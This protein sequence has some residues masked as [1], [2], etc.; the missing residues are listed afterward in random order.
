MV[1]LIRPQKSAVV[2]TPAPQ[3]NLKRPAA[4]TLPNTGGST[5]VT[6]ANKKYMC[7]ISGCGSSFP[8]VCK[9][10]C[11]K[12]R[13][14]PD[15]EPID[16][17]VCTKCQSEIVVRS[18]PGTADSEHG[19]CSKCLNFTCLK[20]NCIFEHKTDSAVLNHIEK[21]HNPFF[22]QKCSRCLGPKTRTD[23]DLKGQC[24]DSKCK[25]LWCLM[26]GCSFDHIS[27]GYFATH[28]TQIHGLQDLG[29]DG[30]VNHC[31]CKVAKTGAGK[32]AQC[33]NCNRW[34][35]LVR[36]C[37]ATFENRTRLVCHLNKYHLWMFS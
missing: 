24:P 2:P 14:H 32:F 22:V 26:E 35:C 23:G 37:T 20:G 15:V 19:S 9:L 21:N 25:A 13:C 6:P 30:D 27:P 3:M 34:W 31:S 12:R 16:S 7:N 29:L 18:K 11:H 5:A 4:A 36:P 1:S 28:Q 17:T 33:P 10:C 8:S